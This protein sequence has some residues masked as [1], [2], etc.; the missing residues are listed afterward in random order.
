M[1]TDLNLR[2]LQLREQYC[3][4]IRFLQECGASLNTVFPEYLLDFNLYKKYIS[5]DQ[6]RALILDSKW[7][8]SKNLSL[9]WKYYHKESW[10]L[11]VYQILNMPKQKNSKKFITRR[12][13]WQKAQKL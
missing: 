13:I 9:Q 11:L 3:Q 7:D 1:E 5:L 6:N 8:K 2:A 12:K 10:V 4:L